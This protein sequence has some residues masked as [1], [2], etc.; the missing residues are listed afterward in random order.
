MQVVLDTDVMVAALRSDAGASRRLLVAVL[1]RRLTLL[2]SVPLLIEYEAVMTRTEH[3][4]AA[5]VTV[6]DVATIL[7]AVAA[8][9]RPVRLDFLWRAIVKDPNDDMVL[10]T[11]V[12][13]NAQAIVTFNARDLAR[14]AASFGIETLLP[15]AALK[16]LDR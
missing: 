9:A 12:N 2:V 5:S 16:R 13:G 11:A 15:R 10:G 6:D 7:D 4:A 14:G 8:N 3:L 1:D